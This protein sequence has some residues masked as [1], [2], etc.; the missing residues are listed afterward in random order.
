MENELSRE[1]KIILM[2]NGVQIALEG[3]KLKSFEKLLSENS[4]SRFIR[5]EG[6]TINTADLSGVFLPRDVEELRYRNQGKWQCSC[7][8]WIDK[9][10]ECDA[11]N[12]E[13]PWYVKEIEKNNK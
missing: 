4:G 2:R 6:R 11:C 12:L 10:K 8:M 7:G 13:K 3:E 9:F 5:L 1:L